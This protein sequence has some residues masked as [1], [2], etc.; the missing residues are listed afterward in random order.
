MPPGV[1]TLEVVDS[2]N[3]WPIL[4]VDVGMR[5]PGAVLVYSP[6]K[7]LLAYPIALESTGKAQYF[8]LREGFNPRALLMNPMAIMMIFSVFSMVILPQMMKNMDPETLKEMQD[9]QKQL[10][11]GSLGS[12][13]AAGVPGA[14]KDKKGKKAAAAAAK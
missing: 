4:E 10:L 1:Y 9:T 7:E 6:R 12:L 3:L 11:G 13:A 5:K 8:E 14:I 2:V